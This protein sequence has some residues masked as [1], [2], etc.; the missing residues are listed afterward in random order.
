MPKKKAS[1][2][3]INTEDKYVFGRP[4]VYKK[5]FEKQLYE[6]MSQ[7]F[8]YE[9]FAGKIGVTRETLYDWEKKHPN[10]SYMKNVGREAGLLTY[11]ELVLNAAKGLIPNFNGTAAVWFGKN[12]Y[13]WTDRRDV[14]QTNKNIEINIDSEDY[15]M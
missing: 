14:T 3:P 9:S 6:H 12:V 10:F 5:A 8:S 11:E 1:K 4:T 15:D 7:G 13:G 2:K